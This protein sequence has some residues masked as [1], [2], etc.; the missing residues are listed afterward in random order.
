VV[1]AGAQQVDGAQAFLS[2]DPNALVVVDAA[3]APSNSIIAGSS[4][5][6]HLANSVDN[7]AGLIS[8]SDGVAPGSAPLTGRFTLATIRFKGKLP[9][10]GAEVAF[11]RTWPRE[12]K[13]TLAGANVLGTA[14]GGRY[15]VAGS[16]LQGT[17]R[18]AGRPLPPAASQAVPLRV[19]LYTAGTA[20]LV[21]ETSVT[22]DAGGSFSVPVPPGTYDIVVKHSQSLSARVRNV[23]FGGGAVAVSF[24]V[25]LTG[26]ANNDD[27]INMADFSTL[28][29]TF[30][31]VCDQAGFDGS[32]DFNADCIVDISDFSLLQAGFLRS[33]PIDVAVP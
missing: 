13:L 11:S 5:A 28:R 20:T 16:M 25:L 9:S 12:S 27:A 19:R 21:Q 2:F 3:G 15:Q 24:G 8:Y 1:D 26:D 31:R 17:M 23:T 18:L 29:T 10:G 22:S 32:A 6:S 33:G 4:F 30:L 7:A 14:R